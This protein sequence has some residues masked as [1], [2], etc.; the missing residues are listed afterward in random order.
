M[1]IFTLLCSP[2]APWL[3]GCR[4]GQALGKENWCMLESIESDAVMDVADAGAPV[5]CG[6]NSLGLPSHLQFARHAGGM[7]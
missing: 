4:E 1:L 6:V 2:S 5:C 7:L 3:C